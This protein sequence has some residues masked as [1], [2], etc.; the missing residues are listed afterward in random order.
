MK[1]K[2][3]T[4]QQALAISAGL[5]IV[6]AVSA[7]VAMHAPWWVSAILAGIAAGLNAWAHAIHSDGAA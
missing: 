7:P 1:T 3:S 5:A 4:A 6:G 2:F